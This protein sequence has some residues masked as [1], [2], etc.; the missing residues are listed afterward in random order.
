MDNWVYNKELRHPYCKDVQELLTACIQLL[1]GGEVPYPGMT[2]Y[3]NND[4][5]VV[6]IPLFREEDSPLIQEVSLILRRWLQKVAN[7][8]VFLVHHKVTKEL[9]FLY[10]LD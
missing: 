5:F 9:T 8:P 2:I 10:T 1:E 3:L 7:R 4:E 6:K